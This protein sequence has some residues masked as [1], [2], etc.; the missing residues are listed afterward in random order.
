MAILATWDEAGVLPPESTPDASRIV[1]ALIQFQGAMMKSAHPQVKQFFAEAMQR[2]FGSEASEQL[3]Q[4]RTAGWS[5]RRL[6][7]VVEYGSDP[8]RGNL[9]GLESGWHEYNV[10]SQDLR[11][12]ANVHTAAKRQLRTDGK[13]LHQLFEEK[14]RLMPGASATNRD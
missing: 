5:S 6:E 8:Q 1:K 2:K 3:Q 13:D 12:L 9:S 4:G 11:L 14:R 7:A 10:D